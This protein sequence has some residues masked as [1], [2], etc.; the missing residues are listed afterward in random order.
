MDEQ[1]QAS[2]DTPDLFPDLQQRLV[3]EWVTANGLR[4]AFAIAR[5]NLGPPT[6]Q[7][8]LA[9]GGQVDPL[10]FGRQNSV[11]VAAQ[12]SA[13]A[14]EHRQR[15]QAQS[16]RDG[17]YVDPI[18]LVEGEI[19]EYESLVDL[20]EDA[21]SDT[22]LLKRKLESLREVHQELQ[23]RKHSENQLIFRDA[24]RVE[25]KLPYSDSGRNYRQFDVGNGRI[26][27]LRVL[28]PDK[29]EHIIGADLVYEHYNVA[30]EKVRVAAIQYKI[31]D[32][33]T[34][35][36]DE[37]M[38][39]QLGKLT[40]AFCDGKIC[41]G[42]PAEYR[43]PYCAAFLRPTDNLQE[44]DSRL[45]STGQ[46]IPVCVVRRIWQDTGRGHQKLTSTAIR[47]QAVTHRLFEELFNN[48]MLGSRW[49]TYTELEDIYRETKIL[50][51][52]ERVIIHAQQFE[53]V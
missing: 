14:R 39:E 21:L 22:R 40:H 30:E 10:L 18:E 34:L 42:S 37:R 41:S 25:R 7:Q 36:S 1:S 5:G 3:A 23:S 49:L 20:D 43:L 27:R 44:P 45:I 6:Y 8:T 13:G 31:W 51:P 47:G 26:L 38:L 15:A 29:P 17:I 46:H 28:H 19:R 35:Y 16:L 4:E 9:V 53:A 12:E 11:L 52:D 32:G 2:K 24:Y 50:D 33:K 48:N